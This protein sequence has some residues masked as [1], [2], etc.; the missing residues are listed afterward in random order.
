MVKLPIVES[1]PYLEPYAAAIYGR[2]EYCVNVEKKLTGGNQTLSDFAT[3]YLYFGL[4]RLTDGW[5]FREWAPNA[6][7]IF[8]IGAT[9][10]GRDLGPRLSARVT[11]GLTA[12]CTRLEIGEEGELLMTRP[13][14]GG[15]LMATIVCKD[16]KPQ[17]STVRPG[18][19]QK[20]DRD[21]AGEGHRRRFTAHQP[22]RH[23]GEQL[24]VGHQHRQYGA[25]L[26]G[27]LERDRAF[28]GKAQNFGNENEVARGRDRQK[29]GQTFHYPKQDRLP[30]V[31]LHGWVRS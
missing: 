1:D 24:A 23:A 21:V 29:L 18:V 20:A 7:A 13:A 4:H 9:T 12:D 31:G 22:H 8:L 30:D 15:N 25:K 2:Y 27:D 16:H 14:F 11:T 28:A 17:M 26:D 10:I 3:G 5:V 19:M 6:T